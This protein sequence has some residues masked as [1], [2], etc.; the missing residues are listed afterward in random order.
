MFVQLGS[1]DPSSP[2]L[3]LGLVIDSLISMKSG[4]A[5]PSGDAD[6]TSFTSGVGQLRK[7]GPQRFEL[8]CIAVDPTHRCH[9]QVEG[10]NS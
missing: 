9:C 6:H 2:L 8:S 3:T 1:V 10:A 7:N 4:P 5:N